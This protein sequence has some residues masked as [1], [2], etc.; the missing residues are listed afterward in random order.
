MPP[1]SADPRTALV[2][3]RALTG[4]LAAASLTGSAAAVYVTPGT[5]SS[6]SLG[7][8]V[9]VSD[10]AVTGSAPNFELHESVVLSARDVLTMSAGT[11][12]EVVDG[13]GTVRLEINGSLLAVGAAPD[14]I[15][16]FSSTGSP[17]DWDGI[18]YRDTEPGSVFE[19]RYC[20]VEDATIAIDVVYDD[21]DLDHCT[22]RRSSEKA[23][24]LTGSN[25]VL[26]NSILE[27]N[28]QQTIYMT[29]SSSPL[30]EN[31]LIRRNN[32]L[33][34]SPHPYIN[35]G[36]QGVNS[37]TIRANTILG[38]DSF[39][40]GGISIW[41]ECHAIIE[42]NH[43]EGCGY[44]I[45]CYQFDANPW[46]NDNTL[47]DNDTNP[48][49]VNWGFGIACNGQN[50]P[51]IS[52][53]R[54][55][56]HNYGIAIVN[57]AQPNV[58][59]LGNLDPNDDGQN[60]FLG[61]GIGT[62]LYELYNNDSLDVVAENNWWGTTDLEGIEDRIV[63]TVDDSLLGAVDFHPILDVVAVHDG[64]GD[65]GGGSPDGIGSGNEGGDRAGGLIEELRVSPNPST[66][67]TD[68]SFRIAGPRPVS[69]RVFDSEGRLVRD[70]WRG[71]L[72]TGAHTIPWDAE[73]EQSRAVRKGIYF[74]RIDSGDAVASGK[75]A[76]VR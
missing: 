57:G 37:P 14:S 66:R 1:T 23:F 56:G 49:T 6:Y 22:I 64:L 36:L 53:N 17:G 71:V 51:V 32:R 21:V 10:G 31:N 26:R 15:R 20:V 69:I 16:I 13:T 42:R 48:D 76:I 47:V 74:W 5:G 40:S 65:P 3:V 39:R 7:D 44:G 73:D 27:D 19:M 55:Q 24:D 67:G 2:L 62:A 38:G 33:N 11:R 61:N 58:G 60:Q 35:I 29:L 12:L 4:L 25:S 34:V 18:H 50:A 75:I 41:N 59:D 30:I 43:I 52:R 72:P 28:E 63:H 8:L 46:I 9:S 54:I 68:L 70:L 45:L